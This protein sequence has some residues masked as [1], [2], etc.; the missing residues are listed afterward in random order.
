MNDRI[1]ANLPS[2]DFERTANFYRS[3]GFGVD[4]RGEGW[5]ILSRGTLEL[6]FFPLKLKPKK[7]CFS[8]SVRVDD[9]D[10]LHAAFSRAGITERCSAIPRLSAI[11]N[12]GGLR[13]FA[14]VDPDGSLL[15]C[16]D[17]QSTA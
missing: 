13:L 2:N 4:F 12:L 14:L 1:T 16:V 15:R 8:A 11:E 6:E 17:N 3:L 9:L 5:M 7:S 10:A